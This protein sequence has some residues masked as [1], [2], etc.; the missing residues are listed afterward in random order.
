M[1]Q[2]Q[3]WLNHPKLVV[4]A[5]TTKHMQADHH[6]EQGKICGTPQAAK[7]LMKLTKQFQRY[8]S[9]F[10][11]FITALKTENPAIE[12]QQRA[13]RAL[14]WDKA[15]RSLDAQERNRES[16]IDQQSYVYQNKL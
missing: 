16:N 10:T 6:P 12:E 2:P 14:L 9:E 11:Q 15:P 7:I 5:K 1:I 13:G 3:C 8:E 4:K